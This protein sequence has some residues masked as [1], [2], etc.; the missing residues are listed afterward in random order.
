MT[1]TT[2]TQ[3]TSKRLKLQQLLATLMA[4]VGIIGLVA[5]AQEPGANGTLWGVLLF[6]GILWFI[7]TR[8][9]IWWHHG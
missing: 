5:V 4:V 6:L 8:V 9:R 7:V 2:T 3:L 1:K